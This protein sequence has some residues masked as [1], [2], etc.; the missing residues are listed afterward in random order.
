MK[1]FRL[2]D[3]SRRLRRKATDAE[4]LLWQRLRS[5]ALGVRF[6]RQHPIP[7]FIADFACP[8]ARLVVEVDGSQHG[9]AADAARDA[10]LESA[11]WRVVRF[12]NNEVLTNTEGVVQRITGVLAEAEG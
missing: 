11:G 8:S 5:N 9:G 1:D 10:A 4:R 3:A 6:R 7:P 12:W 2:R